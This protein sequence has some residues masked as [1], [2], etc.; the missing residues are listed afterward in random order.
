MRVG[1][2]SQT[3]HEYEMKA[4]QS[5]INNQQRLVDGQLED[6]LTPAAVQQQLVAAGV[7]A[8]QAQAHL[9]PAFSPLRGLSAREGG[10]R[11]VG[12]GPP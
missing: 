9:G 12:R 6:P 1:L 2:S 5:T 11:F 4:Q 3:T 8:A 7:P 10:S